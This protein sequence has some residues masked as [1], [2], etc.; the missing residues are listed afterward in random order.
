MYIDRRAV[1]AD[2]RVAFGGRRDVQ[3]SLVTTSRAEACHLV[4]DQQR[5][6]GQTLWDVRGVISPI[7]KI[8]RQVALPSAQDMEMAVRAWLAS[9][10]ERERNAIAVK[11]VEEAAPQ[12]PP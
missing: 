3:K 7:D 2:V 1:P 10:I 8:H 11:T 4:A 6:F 9:G 5:L 12:S